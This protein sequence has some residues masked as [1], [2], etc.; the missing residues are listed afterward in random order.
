M[1]IDNIEIIYS[2]DGWIITEFV[3]WGNKTSVM[4]IIS[5][6]SEMVSS[7]SYKSETGNYE[8]SDT[9]RTQREPPCYLKMWLW[10][11]CLIL[12]YSVDIKELPVWRNVSWVGIMSQFRWIFPPHINLQQNCSSTFSPQ[13][14]T[15]SPD[16]KSDWWN[17]VDRYLPVNTSLHSPVNAV[18]S[19]VSRIESCLGSHTVWS[20]AQRQTFTISVTF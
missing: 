6:A 12:M 14:G 15:S 8:N 13:G 7:W 16:S 4:L 11:H 17:I 9:T 18:Y 1:D 20:A 2:I 19:A 5:E 3:V 10:W